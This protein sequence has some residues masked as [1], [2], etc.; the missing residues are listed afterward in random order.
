MNDV[1][2]LNVNSP[3]QEKKRQVCEQI[4]EN[5]KERQLRYLFKKFSE[6]TR[7]LITT[8]GILQRNHGDLIKA[9][10]AK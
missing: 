10:K 6:T 7:K 5:N 8:I 9:S 1:Q 4:K 3:H 2:Q